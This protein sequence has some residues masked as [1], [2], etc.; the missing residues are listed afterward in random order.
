MTAIVKPIG[1]TLLNEDYHKDT[2]RISKSGLDLVRKSPAHYHA[3]YLDTNAPPRPEKEW[4]RTGNAFGMAVTEPDLFKEKF[5]VLDDAEKC[6][7]IGGAKP[8]TTKLYA[9]W[10]I[11]KMKEFGEGVTL[12]EP[13]EYAK[14][15][16]MRDIF[17][18]HP[19]LKRILAEGQAERTLYFNDQDTGVDVRI[20]PDWLT[21]KMGIILDLKTSEDA[22]PSHFGRSAFNFRYHVQDPLYTDGMLDNGFEVKGFVFGVIEKEYPHN[23][24]CYFIPPDV[25]KIGRDAYKEDLRTYAG[26]LATGIWPGYSNIIEPLQFPAYAFTKNK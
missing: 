25:V 15:I 2:S 24:A 16:L 18:A 13:E 1:V 19:V 10:L 23:V 20:R 9:A 5:K 7:E 14:F 4:M 22:G 3:R 26:C 17:R 21:E 11:E 6:K 8:R 12:L